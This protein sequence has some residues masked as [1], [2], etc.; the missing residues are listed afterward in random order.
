[1]ATDG[2]TVLHN[3]GWV[4]T[5]TVPRAAAGLHRETLHVALRHFVRSC[6]RDLAME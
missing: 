3:P 6:G 2:S 1:M 5:L 4:V